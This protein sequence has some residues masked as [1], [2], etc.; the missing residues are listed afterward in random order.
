MVKHGENQNSFGLWI[1]RFFFC[2]CVCYWWSM[3]CVLLWA[4]TCVRFSLQCGCKWC[5]AGQPTERMH[6]CCVQTR[7]TGPTNVPQQLVLVQGTIME[8]N[9]RWVPSCEE[10]KHVG[11]SFDHFF[12]QPLFFKGSVKTTLRQ[13]VYSKRSAQGGLTLLTSHFTKQASHSCYFKLY[14]NML[15][16][17]MQLGILQQTSLVPCFRCWRD[18]KSVV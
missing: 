1:L 2:V 9:I 15:N 14:L 10:K 16:N 5:W 17:Q 3:I 4:C 18:R 13:P 11:S 6:L 7:P 8:M 12:W